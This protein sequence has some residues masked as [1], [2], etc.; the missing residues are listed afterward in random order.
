MVSAQY[1][2]VEIAKW[3][4]VI[5]VLNLKI[6]QALPADALP[7][8]HDDRPGFTC[9]YPSKNFFHRIHVVFRVIGYCDA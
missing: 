2:H 3:G 8:A 7:G 1:I 6:E 5:E 4:R 9:R